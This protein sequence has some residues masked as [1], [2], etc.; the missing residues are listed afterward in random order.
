[1][2]YFIYLFK[3]S[4]FADL[5]IF[6]GKSKTIYYSKVIE[7]TVEVISPA[8]IWHSSCVQVIV[9]GINCD[10]LTYCIQNT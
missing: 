5:K 6:Q 9:A 8:Y 1:M 10:I 3:N 4:L 7:E 2:I